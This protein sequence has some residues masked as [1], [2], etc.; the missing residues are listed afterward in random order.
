MPDFNTEEH[1][2][3]GVDIQ[4]VASQADT[5]LVETSTDEYEHPEAVK[6]P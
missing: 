6:N 2:V 1:S 3:E 5:D 4:I